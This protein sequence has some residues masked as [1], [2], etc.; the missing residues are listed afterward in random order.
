MSFG[1]TVGVTR[2]FSFSFSHVNGRLTQCLFRD[3][4]WIRLKKGGS[5]VFQGNRSDQWNKIRDNVCWLKD[6]LTRWRP[7][8]VI[9]YASASK[10]VSGETLSNMAGGNSYKVN[11]HSFLSILNA[12]PVLRKAALE[13]LRKLIVSD[14][15]IWNSKIW[16][17]LTNLNL[18]SNLN[19]ISIR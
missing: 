5:A 18:L 6:W 17:N 11:P 16:W 2:L 8:T 3:Q 10:W 7:A 9:R 15:Q 13:V 19:C 14:T 12:S 1:A 4:F